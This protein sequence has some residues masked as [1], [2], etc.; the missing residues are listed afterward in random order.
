MSR[1][2]MVPKAVRVPDELW[3]AAQTKAD[4]RGEYLSEVIRK[5][6]ERY[7]A[8]RSAVMTRESTRTVTGNDD[9]ADS[10]EDVDEEDLDSA[11]VT[12]SGEPYAWGDESRGHD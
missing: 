1:K 2:P 8:R 7:V 11:Y 4:E 10:I 6:L 3:K 12:G 9:E 5:A